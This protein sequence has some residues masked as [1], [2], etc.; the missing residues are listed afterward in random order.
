MSCELNLRSMSPIQQRKSL[1]FLSG[2]YFQDQGECI[3]EAGNGFY[4][5]RYIGELIVEG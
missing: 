3:S 5:V 4:F 1:T 2:N